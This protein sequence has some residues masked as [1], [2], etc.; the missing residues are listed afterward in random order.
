MPRRMIKPGGAVNW[1]DIGEREE[2]QVVELGNAVAALLGELEQARIGE[3]AV[4]E[5]GRGFARAVEGF[6]PVEVFGG[7]RAVEAHTDRATDRRVE[8]GEDHVAAADFFRSG[9]DVG[10]NFL[11]DAGVFDL[12]NLLGRLETARKT[13]VHESHL[14][15]PLAVGVMRSERTHDGGHSRYIGNRIRGRQSSAGLRD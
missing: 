1:G 15:C 13:L 9:A 14:S 3:R 5:L 4:V 6:Q 12:G 2:V 11:I 8:S 10:A 7:D